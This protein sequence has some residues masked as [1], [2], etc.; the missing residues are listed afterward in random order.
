MDT[1]RRKLL[2][3]APALA[4]TGCATPAFKNAQAALG[5]GT[6][7][8]AAVP[9]TPEE[10]LQA[11]ISERIFQHFQLNN[12]VLIPGR[13]TS[14]SLRSA[15]AAYTKAVQDAKKKTTLTLVDTAMIGESMLPLL[16]AMDESGEPSR[17]IS[18]SSTLPTLADGII[19]LPP[20]GQVT[21]TLRG[22]CLDRGMPTPRE[23]E[24]L[25]LS[26]IE[27]FIS[28]ELVP[29]M[30]GVL[31]YTKKHDPQTG[32][33]LREVVWLLREP[34]GT[35]R[36]ANQPRVKAALERAYPGGFALYEKAVRRENLAQP[37][38]SLLA[39]ADGV[40][41][42]DASAL[43]SA[44]NTFESTDREMYE[45]ATRVLHEPIPQDNSKYSFVQNQFAVLGVGRAS[46]VP[47]FTIINASSQPGTLDLGRYAAISPRNVQRMVM[48][49]PDRLD[50]AN[51]YPMRSDPSSL[52]N[53]EVK[54]LSDMFIHDA[55]QLSPMIVGFLTDPN[56]KTGRWLA[57][58]CRNPATK[59]LFEACPFVGNA[60]S[61]YSL[62]TG[63][64]WLSGEPLSTADYLLNAWGTIPGAGQIARLAG[65]NLPK[66]VSK[67]M[68]SP[69][70]RAIGKAGDYVATAADINDK[71]L[72]NYF[73]LEKAKELVNAKIHTAYAAL[74]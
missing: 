10:L 53:A 31:E 70:A 55:A 39:V 51:V 19:K 18:A 66:V 36:Y 62:I 45:M 21:V 28:P 16:R 13:Q 14:L 50:N 69:T 72:V 64:D 35:Q 65:K 60:L 63:K 61:A 73:G 29:V 24:P 2:I 44:A 43:S 41:N 57:Q 67:M 42:M 38:R 48:T 32:P 12:E 27:K 11:E 15:K 8:G 17:R 23:N 71:D 52:S 3:G 58:R 25:R 34:G 22:L 9:R 47:R 54:S 33:Y 30:R 37:L 7:K 4:L 59:A 56:R 40:A 20:G 46:L 1:H 26:P 68:A 74:A 5:P 49:P 6:I